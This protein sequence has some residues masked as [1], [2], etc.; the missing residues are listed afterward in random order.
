MYTFKEFILFIVIPAIIGGI[1]AP[2]LAP[3]ILK[4][5]NFVAKL[6]KSKKQ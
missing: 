4:F 1:F 2:Y 3:Y 5:M 6:F